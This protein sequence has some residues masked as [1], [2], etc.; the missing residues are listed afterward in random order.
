MIAMYLLL[1]AVACVSAECAG[2]CKLTKFMAYHVLGDVHRYE[3]VSVVHCDGVSDEVGG[4]HRSACPSLDD[5]LLA[6]FV[7]CEHLLL[8]LDINIWTFFK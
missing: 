6:A 8:K 7:H 3:F 4:D 1:L 2:Q 5:V